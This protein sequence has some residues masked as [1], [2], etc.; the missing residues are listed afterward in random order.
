M[1]GETLP[2]V[3]R[4]R[5]AEMPFDLID[6]DSGDAPD[7]ARLFSERGWSH[8]RDDDDILAYLERYECARRAD[9]ALRTAAHA[10][11]ASTATGANDDVESPHNYVHVAVGY[12]MTTVSFAAFYP[13]FF[14]HHGNVDRLYEACGS[15]RGRVSDKARRRRGRDGDLPRYQIARTPRPR[16]ESSAET[17]RRR[18]RDGDLPR[19]QIAAATRIFRRDRRFR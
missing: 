7:A 4:E 14:M 6:A 3:L 13:A 5:F 9:D 1:N 16:R 18:G 8:V 12:P 2:K 19:Y 17:S 15:R 10:D 11:A